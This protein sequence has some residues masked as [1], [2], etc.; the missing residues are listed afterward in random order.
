[1]SCQTWPSHPT[2]LEIDTWVWL[3]DLSAKYGWF[4]ELD[5]VPAAE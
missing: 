1:M 4:I 3:A 2:V 5:S